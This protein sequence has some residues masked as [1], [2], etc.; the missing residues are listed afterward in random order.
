[1]LL[2]LLTEVA[3]F[4]AGGGAAGVL[5]VLLMLAV[6]DPATTRANSIKDDI[7][8]HHSFHC[9]FSRNHSST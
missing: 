3:S 4:N 7:D 5:V 8:S 9:N 6:T 1:M 2:E